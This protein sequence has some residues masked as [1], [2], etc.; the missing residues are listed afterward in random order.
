MGIP[1]P[2]DRKLITSLLHMFG[3]AMAIIVGLWFS[4]A[5]ELAM[6]NAANLYVLQMKLNRQ[7]Q[8]GIKYFLPHPRSVAR[9]ENFVARMAYLRYLV[10]LGDFRQ[11]LNFLGENGQDLAQFTII[12]SPPVDPGYSL[13]PRRCYPYPPW[14]LDLR[15]GL[16]EPALSLGLQ[17]RKLARAER[18]ARAVNKYREFLARAP[19]NLDDSILREYH[20]AVAERHAQFGENPEALPP[21]PFLQVEIPAL[22]VIPALPIPEV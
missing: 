1:N 4:G 5:Y 12:P 18:W 2:G 6:S 17:A 16:C 15:V 14:T 3:V 7:W 10:A 21:T 11:A 8:P 19:G 22:C 20:L 9:I 13:G